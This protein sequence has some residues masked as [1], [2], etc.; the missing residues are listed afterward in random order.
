[1]SDETAV[2]T[3]RAARWVPGM[4][5]RAR[6]TPTPGMNE[7]TLLADDAFEAAGLRLPEE[8][9]QRLLLR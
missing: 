5:S 7:D 1:M 4:V 2:C 6:S 8:L 3:G 9:A